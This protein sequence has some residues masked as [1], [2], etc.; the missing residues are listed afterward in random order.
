MYVCFTCWA[1]ISPDSLKCWIYRPIFI[2]F[3]HCSVLLNTMLK[4]GI[5]P[6]RLSS[7]WPM[8]KWGGCCWPCEDEDDV[9][10]WWNSGACCSPV[11]E[12]LMVKSS[13]GCLA[14]LS[15]VCVMLE[16]VGR[17]VRCFC[18][19]SSINWYNACKNSR[20]HC[21]VKEICKGFLPQGSPLEQEDDIPFLYSW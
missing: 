18:Q 3:N 16:N 15:R 6:H 1:D 11:G 19:A 10:V 17:C 20:L 14:R 9:G 12:F 5:V 8:I 2:S 4:D 7:V 13:C 21:Y